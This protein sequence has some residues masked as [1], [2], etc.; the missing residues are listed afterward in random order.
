M[1]RPVDKALHSSILQRYASLHSFK[2]IQ[3]TLGTCFRTIERVLLANNIPKVISPIDRDKE[4]LLL[5][6]SIY[7]TQE[8]TNEPVV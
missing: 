3:R 2:S 6:R 1:G 8:K 7:E 5:L 4:L